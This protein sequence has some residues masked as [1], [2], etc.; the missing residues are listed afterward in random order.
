MRSKK[1]GGVEKTGKRSM[2]ESKMVT[3]RDAQPE[4]ESGWRLLWERYCGGCLAADVTAAT[5]RRILDPSASIGAIMAEVDNQ[6][7][8]FV[9]YVEHEG[10][11]ELKKLC[12]V[13][14]LYIDKGHRG[15]VV[16]VGQALA[17]ELVARLERG[18]W[19]RLYGITRQD[20]V[21]AQRLYRR[22]SQGEPYMRYVI[23]GRP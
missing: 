14:D 23:K 2:N 8:G 16:G 3:I 5:W 21:V 20:N 18:E 10:T 4:H 15:D 7:V 1:C 19:S 22:F 6:V 9:T 17:S 13:E 11:W 12:Y